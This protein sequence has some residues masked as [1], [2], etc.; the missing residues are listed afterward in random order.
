MKIENKRQINA[1]T[2]GSSKKIIVVVISL[3]AI[4]GA[5]SYLLPGKFNVWKKFNVSMGGNAAA[6]VNGES[7][8]RDDLDFRID[9]T[10]EILQLQGVNLADEKTLSEVKKQVLNDM[11]SEKILLQAANKAGL[12]ASDA[13]V[14]T[15]FDRLAAKFKTKEDFQKE[16]TSRKLTEKEIKEDIAKQI[17]LNKYIEQNVDMKS[18]SATD[19]EINNLYKNYG[20]KQKNMPKLEE[21]K[22]QLANEVKQQKSRNTIL[23]LIDKL[24]KGADIKIFI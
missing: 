13:D 23:E 12:A 7:I 24:K 4:L 15:A 9:K 5:A 20:A 1:S 22:T 2:S 6:V 19:E 17:I 16:L 18:L 21:I 11:I 8:T 14:Q 3:L 10:K